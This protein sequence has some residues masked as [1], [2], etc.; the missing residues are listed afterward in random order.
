LADQ[1]GVAGTARGIVGNS[2]RCDW[3]R[4]AFVSCKSHLSHGPPIVPPL[5][6]LPPRAQLLLQT[7]LPWLSTLDPSSPLAHLGHYLPASVPSP[8][9]ELFHSHGV[10][11]TTHA[12]GHGHGHDT[13]GQAEAILN[14]HAA[15][16]AL[17]SVVVKEWLYRAT[18]KVADQEH[19]P[20]LHANALQ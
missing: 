17:A 14:P 16:F 4:I 5:T 6:V 20:V 11:D 18:K 15:W 3:D 19:S 13:A 10:N 12:H 8:L 2:R 1:T 9:L 7:L